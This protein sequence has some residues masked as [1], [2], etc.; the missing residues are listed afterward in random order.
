MHR[1][2]EFSI[3]NKKSLLRAAI[4]LGARSI[5]GR[6]S[7]EDALVTMALSAPKTDKATLKVIERAIATLEDPLGCVWSGLRERIQRRKVGSFYTP[8]ELAKPMITWL[9]K[10]GAERIVDVACG[11]GRFAA[12]VA[13]TNSQVKIV[14]VDSDPVAT[15]L[16]R[17]TLNVLGATQAK[18]VNGDFLTTQLP[19]FSGKTG[20]VS[21]PPY[22]RFQELSKKLKAIGQA[23]A[24]D[25]D[26]EISGL[27][28]LHAYFFLSVAQC[29]KDGDIGCFL[30]SAEWTENSYGQIVRDLLLNGLGGESVRIVDPKIYAFSGV[31]TTASIACFRAGSAATGLLIGQ[32]ATIGEEDDLD[33]RDSM[34][35]YDREFLAKQ[36]DWK[37][38]RREQAA[39]EHMEN[40]PT[41]G[42]LFR[43]SRGTA[44]GA[45]KFFVRSQTDA[46][47]IGLEKLAVPVLSSA[48]ELPRERRELRES[49]V[50]KV[51]ITV[52]RTLDRKKHPALDRYL[53]LGEKPGDDGKVICER[54]LTRTR[55]PWWS[56][57]T[58][59]PPIIVSYMAQKPPSF[60]FNRDQLPILNIAHG[61]YPKRQFTTAQLKEIVAALNE[62]GQNYLAWGRTYHG[63][64]KKFEPGEMQRLPLPASLIKFL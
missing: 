28:G 56:I 4:D 7:K 42:D 51:L 45:N 33:S 23:M 37:R 21:N 54:T 24:R 60:Y 25:L 55:K 46:Q 18:V 36:R 64:L 63:D 3:V 29:S 30:T 8:R 57:E 47:E 52:P 31:R 50:H 17:A 34:T 6:S 43:V 2:I 38:A 61:L 32:V 20:F 35:F 19:G 12:E 10:H 41:I 9:L 5:R 14:A 27:S 16:T 62:E 13:T 39:G 15:L 59:S 40:G 11:S 53:R 22:V 58:T 48:R 49:D 44:T 26:H 1:K